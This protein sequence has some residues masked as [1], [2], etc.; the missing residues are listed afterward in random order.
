MRENGKRK[1]VRSDEKRKITRNESRIR[2]FIKQAFSAQ[3]V[4]DRRRQKEER[5]V[6]SSVQ[7]WRPVSW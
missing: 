2:S 7:T 1:D 4:S 5:I 6:K 3:E